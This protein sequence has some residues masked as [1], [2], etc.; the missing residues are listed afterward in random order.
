[1]KLAGWHIQILGLLLLL[2]LSFVAIPF[3]AERIPGMLKQHISNN[4]EVQGFNWVSVTAKGRNVSLT[5]DAPNFEASQLAYKIANDDSTIARV[6]NNMTPR[7]IKPYTMKLNW[8]GSM[9]SINGYVPDSESYQQL[10]KASQTLF[11]EDKIQGDLKVGTG[12]PD[13]WNGLLDSS[14]TSLSKLQQGNIAITD[15]TLYVTGKTPYLAIREEIEN[16]LSNYQQIKTTTHIVAADEAESICQKKFNELLAASDIE[17]TASKASINRNSYA[18]LNSL[19]SVAALCPSAHITIE[20]HTDSLGS[21]EANTRLSERRA[22][23]TVAFLF[24]QGISLERLTAVGLGEKRPVADNSTEH[25]R[26]KNRRIEFIVK[27]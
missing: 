11:G 4:L 16:Q 20:G 3:F 18:L 15:K 24:Q 14:L 10:I 13:E 1:M 7:L 6:K 17:F 22:Q 23:A 5:G 9:L 26:S 8:D 2:L 19:A 12:A 21:D 27:P 25:G